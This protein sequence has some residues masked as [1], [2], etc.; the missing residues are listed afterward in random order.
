L[1]PR[2]ADSPAHRS[3]SA[4]RTPGE[5]R[6]L[7]LLTLPALGAVVQ[8]L[9]PCPESTRVRKPSISAPRA[10][11]VR[12]PLSAWR[13]RRRE[14]G[15]QIARLGASWLTTGE[16]RPPTRERGRQHHN[17]RT[18]LVSGLCEDPD[19][20]HRQGLRQPHATRKF[21]A[22][23]LGSSNRTVSE[24]FSVSELSRLGDN[25]PRDPRSGPRVRGLD[26]KTPR[27][28]SRRVRPSRVLVPSTSKVYTSE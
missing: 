28:S 23:S 4:G 20:S 16:R 25:P 17:R 27:C 6:I 2:S 26:R 18:P 7:R 9:F 21:A 14:S 12:S 5:R 3:N 1:R 22:R 15:A 10:G 19:D 24:P 11:P 13:E 8:R